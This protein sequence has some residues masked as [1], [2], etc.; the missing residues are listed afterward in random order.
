MLENLEHIFDDYVRLLKR[1]KKKTYRENMAEFRGRNDALFTD[2]LKS[3]NEAPDKDARIKEISIAFE[4]GARVVFE[5]KGKINIV[6][7][8]DLNLFMIYYVFTTFQLLENEDSKLLC[9]GLLDHWHKSFK[10]IENMGYT[11]YDD[12]YNSFN[13]KIFGIF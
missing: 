8:T 10:G 4:K 12:L 11:T 9:D 3:V 5:K 7:Q 2:I 1:L 13:E 6:R